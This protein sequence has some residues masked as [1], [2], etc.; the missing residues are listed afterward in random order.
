M[1]IELGAFKMLTHLKVSGLLF[2]EEHIKHLASSCYLLEGLSLQVLCYADMSEFEKF[3]SLRINYFN[4][5]WPATLSR[6]LHRAI[7]LRFI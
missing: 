4:T 5:M 1:V 6:A 2:Q 7:V 3:K